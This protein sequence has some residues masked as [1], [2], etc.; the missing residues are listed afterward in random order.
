[1]GRA[2]NRLIAAG[3]AAAVLPGTAAAS[4]CAPPAVL[5]FAPGSSGADVTGGVPRGERDCYVLQASRGQTLSLSQPADDNPA[6]DNPA[7][8]NPADNNIVLQIYRPPWKIVPT[9]TGWTFDGI[10]LPGTEETR[11]T[12]EWT[13][14]LPVDGRYLLVV[15]TSRG[16]GTYRVRIQIR[17]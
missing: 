14:P 12:R 6:D 11:D 1:M 4:G 17:R 16:G 15:G 3:L 8:D 7:D 10:A 13:G 9:A 5:R 2:A